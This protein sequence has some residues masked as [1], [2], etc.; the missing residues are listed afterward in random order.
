MSKKTIIFKEP[1]SWAL[2]GSLIKI[3]KLETV[4][5]HWKPDTE[6]EKDEVP[7]L[8]STVNIISNVAKLPNA[9][10]QIYADKSIAAVISDLT[11]S[12]LIRTVFVYP[13]TV[14]NNVVSFLMHDKWMPEEG[15][16]V[17]SKFS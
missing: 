2:N 4:V 13:E 10:F 16:Y 15:F 5:Y 6:S 14:F 3:T 11:G 12:T 8:E 1:V 7:H 17:L 9:S